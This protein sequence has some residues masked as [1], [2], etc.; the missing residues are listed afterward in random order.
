MNGGICV[1]VLLAALST[2]CLGRPSSNTQD[3]SRAAP[4][5]VDAVLSEHMRQARSTPLSDQQEPKAE[6]GMDTRASLTE[7]LARL[8]SRKG[9]TRRNSTINSRASGLSANHRIKDRDYLGWMDFGRRS[10]EEY[11]YSS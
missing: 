1:C 10:A 5:Q 11:E 7:L 8:I 3:E 4:S 2:S 9:N 6:D